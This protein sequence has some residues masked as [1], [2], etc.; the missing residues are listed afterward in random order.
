VLS[1]GPRLS[2][3]HVV[4]E[5]AGEVGT[6]PCVIDLDKAEAPGRKG[7]A[8]WGPYDIADPFRDDFGVGEPLLLTVAPGEMVSVQIIARARK[9]IFEWRLELNLVVS[10]REEVLVLP[11]DGESFRTA[12]RRSDDTPYSYGWFASPLRLGPRDEIYGLGLAAPATSRTTKA[13]V[14]HKASECFL[15]VV[16]RLRRR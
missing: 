8:P 10:G 11:N 12:S 4:S 1:Q 7:I 5:S 15:R 14:A 6:I 13:G 9:A 2:G 16:A 3:V